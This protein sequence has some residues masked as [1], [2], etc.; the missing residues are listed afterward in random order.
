M[1]KNKTNRREFSRIILACLGILL[2][3]LG[4]EYR[5]KKRPYIPMLDLDM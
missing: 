1:T 3:S 5:S 4:I 2:Q